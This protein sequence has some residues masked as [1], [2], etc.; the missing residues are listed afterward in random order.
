[1]SNK[2]TYS[3]TAPTDIERREIENIKGQYPE[4][5]QKPDVS[6]IARENAMERLLRLQRL[7]VDLP[8]V[9]ATVLAVVGTLIFG[10]GFSL[11]LVWKNY[12]VGVP[13]GM[14]GMV[15]LG[16]IV[17][18]YKWILSHNKC[19]YGAEIVALCDRLLNEKE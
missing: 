15:L 5:E 13:V 17:Y 9:I 8:K 2:F 12:Y 14:A 1:M 7:V 3:Y 11:I 4:Y 10:T 18:I 16:F 19:K 6:G